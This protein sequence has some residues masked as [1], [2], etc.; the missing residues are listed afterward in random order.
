V[1]SAGSVEKLSNTVSL[2]FVAKKHM[3]LKVE[4]KPQSNASVA[5]VPVLD[6]ATQVIATLKADFSLFN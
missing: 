4:L 5:G 2:Q 1:I 3:T 6:P